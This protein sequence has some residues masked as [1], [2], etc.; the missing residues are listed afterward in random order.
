MT[1]GQFPAHGL[2]DI[3]YRDNADW[4]APHRTSGRY[5][6]RTLARKA[7]R[8]VAAGDKRCGGPLQADM[9]ALKGDWPGPKR[10]GKPKPQ[11]T[12]P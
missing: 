11:L 1:S 6:S 3:G 8:L 7:D 9:D 10:V 5:C 2:H 4:V 12:S